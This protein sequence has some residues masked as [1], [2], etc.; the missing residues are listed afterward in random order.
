MADE[1]E[2]TEPKETSEGRTGTDPVP[3][4]VEGPSREA[5]DEG[6]ED[7]DEDDGIE[8]PRKPRPSKVR[9]MR[10]V[11][12]LVPGVLTVHYI[13]RDVSLA[14]DGDAAI[15][16]IATW[17]DQ[18]NGFTDPLHPVSSSA[19]NGWVGIDLEYVMGLTWMPSLGDGEIQ[20]VT[21]DPRP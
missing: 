5:S 2:Y 11:N 21:I 14:M 3:P 15:R 17:H 4:P 10:D 16:A 20:R 12:R 7:R 9:T 19:I 1:N 6:H 18:H 8:E 13:Q